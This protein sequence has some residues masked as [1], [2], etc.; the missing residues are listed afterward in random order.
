LNHS[1]LTWPIG[2]FLIASADTGLVAAVT[3]ITFPIWFAAE[4]NSP[5]AAPVEANSRHFYAFTD[6]ARVLR[7]M[8]NRDFTAWQIIHTRSQ[9]SLLL[10]IAEVHSN[11]ETH[12]HLNADPDGSGGERIALADL[13]VE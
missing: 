3:K 10:A 12:I 4:R 8:V 6:N 13:V 7:F 2:A 5:I 1:P 11:G 9:S